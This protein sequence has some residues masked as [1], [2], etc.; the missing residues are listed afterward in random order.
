MVT[1]TLRAPAA[2]CQSCS[3]HLVLL[4]T[5][6]AQLR[7]LTQAPL[8]LGEARGRGKAWTWSQSL[9]ASSSVGN[10]EM[11]GPE[12]GGRVVDTEYWVDD[13]AGPLLEGELDRGGMG[14]IAQE[15]RDAGRLTRRELRFGGGQSC[16]G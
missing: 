14:P 4:D 1:S 9:T 12:K 13:L 5:E 10:R 2:P 6:A 15:D 7:Q 3:T 16:Q 8:E 11:T